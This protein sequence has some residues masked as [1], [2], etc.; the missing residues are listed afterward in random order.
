[1]Q[2]D[3]PAG[4][5]PEIAFVAVLSAAGSI[6]FGIVPSPLF[7]LARDAGSALGLL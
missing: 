3:S 7:Y 4:P 5:Y 2:T 1:L 6:F